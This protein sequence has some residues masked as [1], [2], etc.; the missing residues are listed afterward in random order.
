MTPTE[1]AYHSCLGLPLPFRATTTPTEMGYR[2]PYRLG[3]DEGVKVKEP[4]SKGLIA[5]VE[6][7]SF[8]SNHI[9][10]K[11]IRSIGSKGDR[12]IEGRHNEKTSP[13]RG[14]CVCA[15]GQRASFVYKPSRLLKPQLPLSLSITRCRATVSE[16]AP[17]WYA[18]WSAIG[19]VRNLFL[20]AYQQCF[21]NSAPKTHAQRFSKNRAIQ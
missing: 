3:R 9:G 13:L 20:E 12:S 17:L 21:K 11:G 7:I 2:Y 18:L 15:T 6:Y 10:S 5:Q 1:I 16:Y 19:E 8:L 4:T 14:L